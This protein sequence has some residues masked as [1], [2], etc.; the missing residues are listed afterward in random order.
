[1]VTAARAV[2]LGMADRVGTL[3]DAVGRAAQLAQS[4]RGRSALTGALSFSS[5]GAMPFPAP[6]TVSVVAANV[7]AEA[8][9]AAEPADDEQAPDTGNPDIHEG[10]PARVKHAR[11]R[12]RLHELE[13]GARTLIPRR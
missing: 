5:T 1:M 12:L 11:R 8:P 13:H 3:A 6:V 2:E 10:P 9:A 7:S 4:P